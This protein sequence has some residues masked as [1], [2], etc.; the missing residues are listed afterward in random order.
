LDDLSKEYLISFYDK[1]FHLHGDRPEALRWTARGQHERYCLMLEIA[2]D[3]T[4]RKILDYGCGKGD[5]YGFLADRGIKVRYTGIDINRNLIEHARHK[6]PECEFRVSDVEE[7]KLG[8]AYDYIFLCGVFNNRVESVEESFRN[9]LSRLYRHARLGMA[10]N[11]LS[12]LAKSKAVELNY[13]DPCELAAFAME[14][15]SPYV[16]LRHDRLAGDFT[17]FIYR[18][19]TSARE[20]R[21]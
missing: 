16:N 4:G 8:E 21:T 5:F 18:N 13:T 15:L 2:D 17:L 12:S 14:N 3:L 20:K 19:P 9:V 1:C 7:E 6:Y 10:A 11:A